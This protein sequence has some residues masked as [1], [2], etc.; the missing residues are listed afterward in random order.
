MSRHKES[1]VSARGQELVISV[2]TFEHYI[3]VVVWGAW[4]ECGVCVCVCMCVHVHLCVY[5]HRGQ[6]SILGVIP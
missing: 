3:L 5:A 6:L 4:G 2:V 1:L